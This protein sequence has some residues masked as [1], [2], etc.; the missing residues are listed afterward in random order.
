MSARL[1][2]QMF[3]L[4]RTFSSNILRCERMFHS[5]A[6]KNC[7]SGKEKKDFLQLPVLKSVG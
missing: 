4:D 7:A 1:C 6:N 5:L 3:D 2:F